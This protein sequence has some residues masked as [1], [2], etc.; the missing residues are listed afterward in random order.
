MSASPASKP[1]QQITLQVQRS[2]W[3]SQH[4][5]RV[6]LGGEG[7]DAFN[8]NGFTDRYVKIHFL[9]PDVEYQEPVDV[10]ALREVLPRD[11][12]PVT[13]TYTVRWIDDAAGEL[14]IDFV[15]H[16]D[17]GL[18]GP[19]AAAAK[20]GDRL[21]FSGPGGAYRPKPEADWYLFAGDESALPAIAA[22]IESLPSD[23]VGQAFIEVGGE[24]D[25]Q[26]IDSPTGLR[27]DWLSRN[28]AAAGTSTVL[29]DAVAASNW[30]EGE[31]DAFVH[32]EREYMKALRDVLFKQR[33]LR[34]DQVS[35]SGYWANGRTEDRFQAEKRE[36]IGKIL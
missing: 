25:I 30:P 29:I 7:F 2:E 19:W 11:Q 6:I 3:L 32:G 15:V 16:G 9:H 18:A 12:W 8:D 27:V 26:P 17:E 23:A 33:G 24:S 13:R 21:I 36:D 5:V 22:A 31:V 20:P 1:R 35:L 4:M 28:G 14:A 34:R 10:F